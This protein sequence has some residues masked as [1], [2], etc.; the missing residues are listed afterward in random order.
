MFLLLD[1]KKNQ[2]L[3]IKISEYQILAINRD[4]FGRVLHN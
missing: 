4:N 2:I 1:A 3:A